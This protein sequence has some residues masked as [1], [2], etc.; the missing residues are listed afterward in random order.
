MRITFAKYAFKDILEQLEY[1]GVTDIC[2]T[3]EDNNLIIVVPE[4]ATKQTVAYI[5]NSDTALSTHEAAA[6]V[7]AKQS[8][9]TRVVSIC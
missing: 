6:P 3:K 7:T 5:Y 2:I 1:S 9:N 4:T 8:K